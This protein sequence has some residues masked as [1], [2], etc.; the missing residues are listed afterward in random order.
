MSLRF[1]LRHRDKWGRII[2]GMGK[3]ILHPLDIFQNLRLVTSMASGEAK[4]HGQE[5]LKVSKR[6]LRRRLYAGALLA[7]GGG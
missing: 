5:A 3:S 7:A 1:L 4:H 6:R 2:I